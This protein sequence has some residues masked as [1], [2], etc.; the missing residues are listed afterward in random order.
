MSLIAKKAGILR[1]VGSVLI[2][3]TFVLLISFSFWILNDMLAL[4]LLIGLIIPWALFS[5]L[6]KLEKTF[7]TNNGAVILIIL[8]IFSITMPLIIHFLITLDFIIIFISSIC[9]LISWHFSLSIYKIKK[10]IFLMSG[11]SSIGASIIISFLSFRIFPFLVIEILLLT[12]G[13]MVIMIS[14]SWMR[15]KGLLNYI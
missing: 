8:I 15:K 3:I 11:L 7:F 14:E 13:M 10:I 4:I 1:L 5:G 9:C 12:I 2:L 6:L